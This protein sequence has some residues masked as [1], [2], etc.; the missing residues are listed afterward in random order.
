MFDGCLWMEKNEGVM[1]FKHPRVKRNLPEKTHTKKSRTLARCQNL[2]C[3]SIDNVGIKF[4][5][6]YIY[7]FLET[8]YKEEIFGMGTG[9]IDI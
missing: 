5:Y 1:K 7:F 6:I 3:F 8:L 2:L 4:M 9:N